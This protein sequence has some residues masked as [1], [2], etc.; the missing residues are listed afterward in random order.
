V[1]SHAEA[2]PQRCADHSADAPDHRGPLGVHRVR[3]A[4]ETGSAERA[5]WE[6]GPEEDPLMGLDASFAQSTARERTR[7]LLEIMVGYASRTKSC[8]NLTP[9]QQR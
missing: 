2:S 8:R 9:K 1:S 7:H 4:F 3:A 6:A 5:T